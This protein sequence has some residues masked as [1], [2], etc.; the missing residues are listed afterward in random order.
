MWR[1]FFVAFAGVFYGGLDAVQSLCSVYD[2]FKVQPDNNKFVIGGAFPLHDVDCKNV[3]PDTVQ[4]IVAIQ[5][6]L[7]HWNQNPVNNHAK[8]GFFA[9]DTCSRSQE[10]M[11]QSLRFLDTVGY[12]EPQECRTNNS[13]TKLLDLL[14]AVSIV[15][16]VT[17]LVQRLPAAR[18]I[19]HWR[20]SSGV[21]G[22][23]RLLVAFD[24]DV[25]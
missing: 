23:Q 6:A 9:G 21:T 15:L 3:L 5:W 11:S 1:T 16:Q 24:E 7:T 20:I 18:A 2:P 4:E 19:P 13:G 8:L 25:E 14:S 10:A 12:H 22:D 17:A